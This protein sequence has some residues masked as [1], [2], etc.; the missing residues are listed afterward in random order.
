MSITIECG[1]EE[2][3]NAVIKMITFMAT[4]KGIRD[5]KAEIEIDGED[6]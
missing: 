6:K 3:C 5:W 2:N 4:P 1:T